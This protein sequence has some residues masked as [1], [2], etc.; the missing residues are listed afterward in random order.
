VA[1]IRRAIHIKITHNDEALTPATGRVVLIGPHILRDSAGNVIHGRPVD[2]VTL[3][4]GEGTL[5][6]PTTDNPD[7]SPSGWPYTCLVDT[8][9][10]RD[11]FPVQVPAGVGPIEFVDLA[12]A[13]APTAV[14]TYSL[15]GHVHTT[16]QVTG[17]VTA[18]N[19]LDGRLDALEASPG[20]GVT[21]HGALTGL[22]D[23]D[24]PQYFEATRLADVLA[25]YA[26]AGHTHTKAAIGLGNVD[27]TSDAN[28][29]VS[30]ATQTALDAKASRLVVVEQR[31]VSG[32]VNPLPNTDDAWLPLSGFEIAIPAV[33]G[34][35]LRLSVRAMR[36]EGSSGAF[37]D[38]AVMVGSTIARYLSSG[39][40]SPS[41]EGDPSWYFA[42]GYLNQS[43]PIGLRVQAG[44]LDGG[45]VRFAVVTKS[46]GSGKLYASAAFPFRWY[47]E[48]T[49]G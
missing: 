21:D 26:T 32:D 18:L 1:I 34:D 4:N 31:I 25:D 6:V 10:Y 43:G 15:L 33:V 11:Q 13:I 7:V 22:G 38:F 19:V 36:T 30:T 44:D 29:P 24:H 27:N 16:A 48:N 17:L 45:Q 14:A 42:G 49:G 39:T 9:V 41:T 5:E 20:G 46:T 23:D 8:D 37:V 28:K 12:P 2:T 47:V 35:W 3:V 40:S